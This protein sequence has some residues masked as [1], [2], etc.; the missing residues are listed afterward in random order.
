MKK[1]N[2]SIVPIAFT[3]KHTK[4]NT[5]ASIIVV[6]TEN[7]SAW[8]LKMRKMELFKGQT[9]CIVIKGK[10]EIEYKMLNKYIDR[11]NERKR[12]INQLSAMNKKYLK[13]G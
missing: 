7:L 5:N 12:R 9:W 6:F 13:K 4:K 2:Q 8:R 11:E 10:D 3:I 1:K